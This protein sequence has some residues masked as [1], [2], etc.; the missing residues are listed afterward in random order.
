MYVHVKTRHGRATFEAKI[1]I[2]KSHV[3]GVML[4]PHRQVNEQVDD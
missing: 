1:G 4:A 2:G 3:T